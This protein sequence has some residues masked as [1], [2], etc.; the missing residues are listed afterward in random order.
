MAT[1]LVRTCLRGALLA[2]ALAASVV[3]VRAGQVQGLLPVPAVTIYPGDHIGPEMLTEK[4]FYYDPD[5]PLAVVEDGAP[6]IGKV[7]RRTLVA[8]KPIPN[9]S[10]GE[11]T[12]I[13]RGKPV[14]ARF[15]AGNLSISTTVLPL[16]SG[17]LG[18]LVQA[19]NIDSGQ[20]ITGIVQADGSLLVG[21]TL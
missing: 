7:A 20:V 10:V 17:A 4:A 13:T 14:E 21:G 5:R 19:R 2:L 8:G 3:A 11:P 12:L 16:Q 9:N 6:L 1:A 18:A 15:E